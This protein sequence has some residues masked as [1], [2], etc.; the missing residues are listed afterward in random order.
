[1]KMK[2]QRHRHTKEEFRLAILKAAREL[3]S[4][5]GYENFSMRKLAQ[6]IGYSPTTIYLYF[7][8]K[9]EL[10]FSICEELFAGM[11]RRLEELK[12]IETE[13]RSL[14]RLILMHYIEFGLTNPEHYKVAFFTSPYVYGSPKEYLERDTLS[15]SAY[16]H[17]RDMVAGFMDIGL[18][19]SGDV[20]A[21]TQ[22][23]W[24][25]VH[26]IVTAA[27]HTRDFPLVDTKVLAE[28]M[29][30]ALLRGLEK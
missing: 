18:L 5:E 24:A 10:L 27:I 29:V 6:K 26:G 16:F 28:T 23:L 4:R 9:D 30:D 3:F 17:F 19:R 20:E 25:G 13:P 8:D 11:I 21:T 14:L 12:S 7:R 22:V 2:E 15:R 1:M